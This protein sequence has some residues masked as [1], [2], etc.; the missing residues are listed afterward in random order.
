MEA[1]RGLAILATNL[2]TAL[3]RAF[4]RRL[5]FIVNFPFPGPQER[6]VIWEKV[7]PP[8]TPCQ[9]VDPARLARLNLTGGSIHNTALNAA[10][11]AAEAGTPVTMPLLL[12]AARTEMRKLDHPVNEADFVWKEPGET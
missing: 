8:Q 11:L 10:F 9:G 4:M 3:D 5:R 2:K 6:K 1:Y 7:F 12:A